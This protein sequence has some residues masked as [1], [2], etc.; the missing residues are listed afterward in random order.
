LGICYTEYA[1]KQGFFGI[2]WENCH[3]CVGGTSFSYI[4]KRLLVGVLAEYCQKQGFFGIFW[5][6]CHISANMASF[7][8]IAK[9]VLVFCAAD[10]LTGRCEKF[11]EIGV[12]I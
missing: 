11:S 12:G 8:Y 9:Q 6:N 3:I 2:F 7:S 5:E 1:Q 4:G 10:F